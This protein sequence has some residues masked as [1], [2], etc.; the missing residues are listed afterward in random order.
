[1]TGCSRAPSIANE[2]VQCHG[3][4]GFI[5][6]NPAPRLYREAPLNSIREGTANMM[7]MDMRRAMMKD[8]RTIEALFDEVRPLKGQDAR[9]D[10]MVAHGER[11]VRAAVADEFHARPMTEAVARMLQGAELLRHSPQEVAGV[12]LD[13]RAPGTPGAW[14][15]HYGTLAA[16]VGQSVARAIMRGA[17][18]A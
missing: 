10:A 15:A 12:F 8:A 14:G 16:P 2:A 18:V 9:Y 6:E 5:E 1:M 13:T 7:C 4:N 11:L 17:M 3:G